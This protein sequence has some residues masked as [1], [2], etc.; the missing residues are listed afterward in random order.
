M[1]LFI[2]FFSLMSLG[3][4]LQN[5]APVYVPNTINTGMVGQKGDI[6]GAFHISNALD[7]QLAWGIDSNLMVLGSYQ[8]YK[9]EPTTVSWGNGN[10]TQV[11]GSRSNMIELGGGYYNRFGKKQR[12]LFEGL[13]GFGYGSSSTEEGFGGSYQKYFAQTSVGFVGQHFEALYSLKPAYVVFTNQTTNLS[14]NIPNPVSDV[15]IEN[16][17]TLRFGSPNIKFTTQFGIS[18]G[19]DEAL[20]PYEYMPFRLS[21]GFVVR[22]NRFNL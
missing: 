18:I 5:C 6:A 3:L 15:F 4:V 22:L 16:A 21:A 8:N 19:T 17:M 2:A 12:G 10:S 14:A 9:V 20:S 7:L 11:G 13:S 1:R